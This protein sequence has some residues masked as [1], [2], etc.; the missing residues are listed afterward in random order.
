MV[1]ALFG[2]CSNKEEVVDREKG[3]LEMVV[4]RGAR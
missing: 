2:F 4:I 3:Y 1:I